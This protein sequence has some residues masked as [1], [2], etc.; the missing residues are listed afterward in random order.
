M[1]KKISVLVV[2]AGFLSLQACGTILK[3][4]QVGKAHSGRLDLGIVALDTVGLVLF[5][6]PGVVAF[7]M[8]YLNGTLYLP[9]GDTAKLENSSPEN[10]QKVLAANHIKV[11]V[12]QIK[13]AKALALN[14]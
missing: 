11:S 14:H 9:A 12:S 3:R 13:Q 8:D 1:F 7:T 6:V 10:I 5:I 4:N 2:L